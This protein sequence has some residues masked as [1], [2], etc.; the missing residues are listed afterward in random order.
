M[1]NENIDSSHFYFGDLK[2]FKIPK[3][4][5]LCAGFPCQPFSVASKRKGEKDKRGSLIWD[6]FDII[7]EHRPKYVILE[8]VMGIKIIDNGNFF[9]KIKKKFKKEKYNIKVKT[10]NSLGIVPQNRKRLF[11]IAW[12]KKL[13]PLNF[14]WK[15]RKQKWKNID[16]FI[17]KKGKNI[18]EKYFYE[19]SSKIGQE[20]CKIKDTTKFYQWRRTKIRTCNSHCPT[21]THNMG[22]GGH[23]VPIILHKRKKEIIPRKLT[24]RECFNLQ[25]FPDN[26]KFPKGLSNSKLYCLAGNSITYS[27][28]KKMIKNIFKDIILKI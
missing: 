20:F 1:Y 12:R 23:N 15:I 27:L 17:K 10:L 3:H 6:V 5:I 18:P 9:K 8:N 24:P 26:W 2:E 7:S 13:I 11:I 21:L 14:D 22:T 19:K 16:K 4:D 25:G 28:V